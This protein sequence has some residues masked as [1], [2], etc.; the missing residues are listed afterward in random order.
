MPLRYRHDFQPRLEDLDRLLRYF[1]GGYRPNKT[2]HQILSLYVFSVEVSLYI[3]K[4]WYFTDESAPS[5]NDASTS[6]IYAT[7]SKH[8]NNT[9]LQ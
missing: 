9:K 1:L 8:T 5:E 6:P 7:Q 4:E 2:A 3:P